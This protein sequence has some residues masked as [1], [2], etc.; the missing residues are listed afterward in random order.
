MTGAIL[1]SE[2]APFNS[3]AA[4]GS[5]EIVVKGSKFISHVAP[6]EKRQD[7]EKYVH[8]IS[9]RYAD[10]T[11]NCFAYK[12]GTGDRALFRFSDDGE[13]S[14]TAGRPILQVIESRNLTNISLVVTRY[15]GGTKLGMGGLIRA[16]SAVARAVLEQSRTVEFF[17]QTTLTLRFAYEHTNAVHQMIDK[18]QADL[19]RTDFEEQAVYMVQL[20]RMHGQR[21]IEELKNMTAGKV[22]IE[23]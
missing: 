17:P 15:F 6:V 21:F 18:F 8:G 7:A 3:I 2:G 4:A 19:L 1:M 11:H 13:P 14:G 20:K 23:G 16:Y 12:L 5:S 10:A 22:A 9:A